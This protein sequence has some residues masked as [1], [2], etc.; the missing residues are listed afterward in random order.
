MSVTNALN[1]AKYVINK[2][3]T[4]RCP[5][6]NLQ[7]QKILYYI[8]VAFLKR[9]GIPCFA[10]EI[11]AWKFG[12][13]VPAVYRKYCGFGAMPINISAT[14]SA[15]LA[16]KPYKALA[17]EVIKSKQNLP[18]WALVSATH[19]PGGAWSRTYNSKG[20]FSVISIDSMKNYG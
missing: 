8:Q 20:S 9:F 12:P 15:E 2:C 16:P 11:E 19:M 5:V 3:I 7:L 18:P 14:D 1:M 17:D 10:D 4:D 13:V 6:S